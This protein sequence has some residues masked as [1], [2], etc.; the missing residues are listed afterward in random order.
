MQ[1]DCIKRQREYDFALRGHI[2]A[3]AWLALASALLILGLSLYVYSPLHRDDPG[4]ARTC[5]FCQLQNLSCQGVETPVAT[6]V[7][8]TVTW[9]AETAQPLETAWCSPQPHHGRAP[10]ASSLSL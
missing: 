3:R 10:P 8:L 5:P 6:G 4:T 1:V 7:S 9:L 2:V